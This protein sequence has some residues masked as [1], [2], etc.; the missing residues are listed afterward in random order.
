MTNNNID[1][2][3]A[4]TDSVSKVF[5]GTDLVWPYTPPVPPAPVSGDYL[6]FEIISGGTI[7]WNANNSASTKTIS[8][9]INGGA[10]TDITSSTGGTSFNVNSG[11]TILFKGEN[12]EYSGSSFSNSTSYFILSGN[13]MSLIYGDDFEGKT[14]LTDL[15]NFV[16]LFSNTKVVNAGGLSL[17]ATTL[18]Y[19]CYASMFAGWASLRTAPVLPAIKLAEGCYDGMFIGCTNLATAPV[20]PATSL[21]NCNNCY[22]AMFRGCSSLRTAPELPATILAAD[23]YYA[24]FSG[25]T[26]L[27]AAPELPATSLDLTCYAKM[28]AGCT[29]LRTAPELPAASLVIGCYNNMFDGCTSLNYIKCLAT[30][31]LPFSD[32]YSS[33]WVRNVASSG[34]FVKAASMTNWPAGDSG[35]PLG[36]TIINNQ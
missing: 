34:T 11:D 12:N 9:S 15:L 25:C 35:I 28:F 10:W 21:N 19:G 20:L 2:I 5:L 18:R 4:G 31:S 26:S 27:T 36:W 30:S 8:Y 22:A 32:S 33:Y 7:N 24:M 13:I 1:K 17:P 16:R 23:C 6:T 29:S 14:A 3:Y